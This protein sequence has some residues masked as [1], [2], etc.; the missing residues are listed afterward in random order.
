MH[1][2][3]IHGTYNKDA[4]IIIFVCLAVYVCLY[5]WFW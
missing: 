1:K 5:G 2:K 4:Y 3:N